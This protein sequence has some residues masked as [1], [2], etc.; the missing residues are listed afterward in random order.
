MPE[1]AIKDRTAIVGIG[2]TAFTRSSGTTALNLALE[3]SIKAVQDA[4]LSGKDI[5]GIVTHFHRHMDT[6]TPHQM[7]HGLGMEKCNFQVFNSVGGSWNCSGVM[8]AAS[9]VHAGICNYVLL[10]R[11]L[12][13]Y[14]EGR[15]ARP[16]R[17]EEVSG[18]DQWRTPFGNHHAAATFGHHATAHMA[19]YGT[20]SL[21]FAH[22]AVTEREH[23]L[24]NQK[25]MMRPKGPITVEDHQN[26]R[27]IV[28][29]F[30]LL[31]CCQESDGAVA[32]IITSTERARDLRQTPVTIMAGVGGSGPTRGW[33][34][35]NAANAAPLLFAGAGIT[36]KDVSFA[37]IYDPFTLMCMIHIEDYGLVKKGE[38]GAWIR[39]GHNK[40]DGELPV[41]THGGL[42]S[43]A[44]IHGQNHVIEAVQQ[45]RPQGVV[46]DFCEGP[47][48]YDRSVCRQ[49]RN[50]EIALVCGEA[51]G[52]SML[53]R[54]G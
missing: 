8:T 54:R 13:R 11:A 43:E 19:R 20:T 15:A 53:L 21:D 23:A 10:Y 37:E 47:H 30:R 25:A 26:S 50:P 49:V 22:L 46:D 42:L 27:W 4:G 33:W 51:G 1:Q 28:Y 41:N 39:E 5:D 34:E 40:L 32:M 48:T 36:P 31:D 29:P 6:A 2:W 44:H 35:T 38:V 18:E 3:A 9:L 16:R 24:L 17:A 45:L 7:V 52:S 12:N 14:S